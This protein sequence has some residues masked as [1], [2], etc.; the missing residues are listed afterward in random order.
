MQ[1]VA[2]DSL[3]ANIAVIDQDGVIIA[4]N[5]CWRLFGSSNGSL[6]KNFI[7]HNYIAV[8][9]SSTGANSEEARQVADAL[10]EMFAGKRD[11][12]S[13]EYSCHLPDEQRWF[14]VTAAPIRTARCAGAVVM[15][16]DI[17]ERKLNDLALFNSNHALLL[18]TLCNVA[19][20]RS[21][22]ETELAQAVCRIAVETGN[23]RM[24]WVGYARNNREKS[25][26]AQASAGFAADYLTKV[27]ISWDESDPSGQGPAGRVI[28]SGKPVVVPDLELDESF[29]PWLEDARAHGFRGVICLPLKHQ[30]HTFGVLVLYPSDPNAVLSGEPEL[31][32]KLAADMAFGIISLRARVDQQKTH[33]AVLRM[34]RGISASTGEQ[35]FEQLAFSMVEALGASGGVISKLTDDLKSA[36][37]ISMVFEGSVVP[38]Q[39]Y[40]LAG[41][42]CG[43]L[44]HM[45]MLSVEG[46]L[47]DR[48]PDLRNWA[49]VD[50]RAYVGVRLVNS[51]GSPI[52]LMFVVFEQLQKH[53]E[54]ISSTLKIFA[55]RAADE[56]ERRAAN[57]LLREQAALLD[58]ARDAIFVRDLDR[59][60]VYWNRGA[61]RIYGWNAEEAIGRLVDDLIYRDLGPLQAAVKATVSTG[62]WIG[63]ITQF[64][65][66]GRELIVEGR[67]SLVRDEQ[68]E[69]KSILA[70]NT[71]ITERKNL[72]KQFLRSQRV[73]SI[74]TLAGGIAHDLNNVLAPIM[75][76]IDLLRMFVEDPI[77]LEILET[78]GKSA[79]RGSDLV[80]QVL[81]FARGVEGQDVEVQV[82]HIFQDLLRIIEET[83]PKNIRVTGQFDKDLWL[84]KA[85]P[86]QL[87]QV[88][89]NLCVNSRDA[90]PEGG[91]ID[92][93]IENVILD[94]HYSGMNLEVNVGPYLKIDVEDNGHGIPRDIIDK[95]FDPFF[96][97]KEVGS[98]TGLGLSTS[99]A[100]IKGLGGFI[101]VYS[102]P[103]NG[104]SFRIYLPAVTE[105]ELNP[106]DRTSADL[107][108]G[109]GETVLVVDDEASI[110][111]ITKKTLEAFG[112]RVLLASDGSEAISV[113]VSHQDEIAVVLTDMMMPIMDGPATIKV[114]RRL[115]PSLPIIGASGIT[116]NG[117]VAKAR[118]AGMNDF[119]PKPYTAESLLKV[120]HKVLATPG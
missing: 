51:A 58:L 118:D 43:D 87:H 97:T 26:D 12:F 13:L 79:R 32:E 29:R 78:V 19:L 1:A 7:G 63:E 70:I 36:T 114:L 112:Y 98:G 91:Q 95:V 71:D 83:F 14:R 100:I 85:D 74:G 94:E 84:V 44:V 82:V 46:N 45:D 25:I 106:G 68:G 15:H 34:A 73:E 20:T 115:R 66:D 9:E 24:A 96:T 31:L 27:H 81:S 21:E 37:T 103:G 107:F 28:R 80:G 49:K 102:D 50:I 35:F 17:T 104:T 8:C 5:E 4:E 39:E 11:R 40:P 53:D 30:E 86:T 47:W 59:R 75:M 23:F 116:A 55:A 92:V 57:S 22:S 72:E 62:A 110:R 105:S 64:A 6:V 52:G 99:L 16:S 88:L 93:K 76:S 119:L 48:Y 41:S 18:L 56:L 54:F 108:R 90:M 61:E 77:G 101:R 65:K 67:W 60:I 69:A 117:K 42:P 111:F 109:K 38:N 113:F 120:I 2:L 3:P 10:R 89:L 33:D